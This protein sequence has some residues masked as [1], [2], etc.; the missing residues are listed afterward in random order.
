MRI[1]LASDFSTS[2]DH[3]IDA[4]CAGSW[5]LDTEFKILSVL[6]PLHAEMQ[7][8]IQQSW[9]QTL[10]EIEAQRLRKLEE[11]CVR[12]RDQLLAKIPQ[13][14]VHYEIRQGQPQSQIIDAAVEWRAD[15]I[16]VGAKSRVGCD[17]FM[18]G[19]VS[20]AIASHAPCSVEIVRRRDTTQPGSDMTETLDHRKD[21]PSNDLRPS[22]DTTLGQEPP[23]GPAP[24]PG[25]GPQPPPPPGPSPP[26]IPAPAPL[27]KPDPAPQPGS[28]PEPPPPPGP[29]PPPIPAPA[30]LPRP[31]PAPQPG[32]GPEPP[33]A[34]G[35][36]RP[37]IPDPAPL[38]KPGSAPQLESAHEPPPVPG[39]SGVPKPDSA[40]R[41]KPGHKPRR[42]PG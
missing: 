19:S 28:G 16:I 14:I 6:T 15:K 21:S 8:Q 27:P 31:D 33:P 1:I 42:K 4:V 37:P 7:E 26:P 36:S 13:A 38:P 18:I 32:S 9:Q 2:W 34:P 20:N 40:L 35:P 22:S 5:G 29:S 41:S 17:R 11:R 23:P 30:P 10:G 39:I 25:S 12:I 24:P 3:M